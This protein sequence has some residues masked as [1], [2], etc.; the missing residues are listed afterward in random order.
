[1]YIAAYMVK[2]LL[3]GRSIQ[4]SYASYL[5]AVSLGCHAIR[6]TQCTISSDSLLTRFLVAGQKQRRCAEKLD[7]MA[8]RTVRY[9]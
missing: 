8:S 1:M 9:F 2:G 3:S 7:D 4:E 6:V 5:D